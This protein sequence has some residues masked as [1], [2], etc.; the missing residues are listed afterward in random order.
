MED[1]VPFCLNM[2]GFQVPAVRSFWGVILIDQNLN[3]SL[4]SSILYETIISVASLHSIATKN[5]CGLKRCH[6]DAGHSIT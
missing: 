6:H 4:A 5:A 3:A 1:D 2:G